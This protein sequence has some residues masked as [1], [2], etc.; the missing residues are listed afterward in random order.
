M[1]GPPGSS[2][3]ENTS[4][5]DDLDESFINDMTERALTCFDQ[6]AVDMHARYLQ[7]VK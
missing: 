4:G 2:D 3:E 5:L 1:S 6:T 7:S